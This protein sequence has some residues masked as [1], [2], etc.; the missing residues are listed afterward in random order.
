MENTPTGHGSA[1]PVILGI[2]NKSERVS[3]V[4]SGWIWP[5][6]IEKS[7][8]Y[9]PELRPGLF[10]LTACQLGMQLWK[11]TVTNISRFDIEIEQL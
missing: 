9:E 5:Q 11:L 10:S 7:I 2:T 4:S 6:I 1:L 3:N 8:L